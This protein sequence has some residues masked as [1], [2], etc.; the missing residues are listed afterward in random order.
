MTVPGVGFASPLP[1][2]PGI[3]SEVAEKVTPAVVSLTTYPDDEEDG[4][5][6]TG[7][8]VLVSSDGL[9]V[10]SQHVV[11]GRGTVWVTLA[12]GRRLKAERVGGDRATDVAVVRVPGEGFATLTLGDARALRLGEFVLAV[13]NP[14]D[15]GL[16]VT[17][18]IVSAL[19]RSSVGILEFEDFVQTDAAINPGNSG[20]ALVNLE[21]ELVGINT[22]IISRTGVTQGVGFAIPTHVVIWVRDQLLEGGSVRHG[23]LGIRVQNVEPDLVSSSEDGVPVGVL[24]ADVLGDPAR[25]AGLEPEDIITHVDG[26]RVLDPGQL[27]SRVGL[28]SPGTNL[29]LSVRRRGRRWS[30]S[31]SSEKTGGSIRARHR[32]RRSLREFPAWIS[33][34]CKKTCDVASR[35]ASRSKA[36]SSAMSS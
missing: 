19:G 30:C 28:S 36:S 25:R 3:I 15:V 20:G 9:I 5:R 22:S 34:H 4:E 10:T 33:C 32:P 2:N 16:T 14:F 27:R 12:D 6:G 11:A 18:G 21:G 24:V 31:Q 7:S 35:S 17:L 29:R 23:W 13:G 8:G 1:W 26:Q